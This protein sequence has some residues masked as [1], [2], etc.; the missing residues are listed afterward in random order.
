[1]TTGS[2]FGRAKCKLWLFDCSLTLVLYFVLIKPLVLAIFYVVIPGSVRD[3]VLT[4]Q[5][6]L[7][8][9]PFPYHAGPRE[10]ASI[11]LQLE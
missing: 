6:P 8:K 10:G 7:D 4:H 5:D 11:S 1:M 2:E 9:S 3:H